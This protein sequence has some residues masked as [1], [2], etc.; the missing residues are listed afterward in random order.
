VNK[1]GKKRKR[2]PNYKEDIKE[3]TLHL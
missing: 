2:R 1:K 3:E